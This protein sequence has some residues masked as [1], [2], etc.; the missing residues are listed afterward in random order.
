MKSLLCSLLT[1]LL[2][3]FDTIK[4]YLELCFNKLFMHAS[5]SFFLLIVLFKMSY[6]DI[7]FL[8]QNPNFY[9]MVK[10]HQNLIPLYSE[11]WAQLQMT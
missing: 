3:T 9:A 2:Q 10:K 4:N 1:I 8:V 5:S 6:G 7:R 11:V